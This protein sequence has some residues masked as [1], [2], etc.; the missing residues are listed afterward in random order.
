MNL[1][2]KNLISATFI[3]YSLFSCAQA[4][5]V[6]AILS[7]NL[8]PVSTNYIIFPETSNIIAQDIAN[9]ININARIKAIPVCNSIKNEQKRTLDKD[10]IKFTRE[11]QATYNLNYKVL[12]SISD[13]LDAR[14]VLMVASSVDPETDFLKETIWNKIP[15]AG[16]NCVT[17]SY[18]ITTHIALIDPENQLILLE[19]NY[20]KTISSKNFDIIMPAFSP[21]LEHINKFRNYS[22]AVTR[23]AVPKIE[24]VLVPG[25]VPVKRTFIDKIKF[26]INNTPYL[27]PQN[28][29]NK[30]PQP[31]E[32]EDINIKPDP[33]LKL[34]NYTNNDL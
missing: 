26:N 33:G 22:T 16:E 11:Y 9:K 34:Y 14:Y 12:R 5:E 3:L 27:I 31:Q 1:S 18:K 29:I 17:P 10:L 23:D 2:L 13:Q 24:N 20:D 8:R 15:I 32:N 21:S 7:D 25:S 28:T 4:K 19:E 30:N 6:M